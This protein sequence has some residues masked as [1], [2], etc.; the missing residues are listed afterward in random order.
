MR[1]IA[2]KAWGIWTVSTALLATG[3][4][5]VKN[6]TVV[7]QPSWPQRAMTAT[8][9]APPPLAATSPA[10]HPSPGLSAAAALEQQ[11]RN[12]EARA[13][14]EAL[15]AQN[16]NDA[17]C[18]HRLAVLCTAAGDHAPAADFYN[19]ALVL[20]P[21]NVD[22]LTDAGYACHVRAE[23]EAAEA[24]LREALVHA[25]RH[26]R[27]FNNLGLVLGQ[28]GRSEEALAA[29]WQVNRPVDAW[30]NMAYVYQ[31]R[32][33]WE[34]ALACYAEAQK[35]DPTVTVPATLLAQRDS[36]ARETQLVAAQ[37]DSINATPVTPPKAVVTSAEAIELPA[38]LGASPRFISPL[39][40]DPSSAPAFDPVAETLESELFELP[41]IVQ[42]GSKSKAGSATRRVSEPAPELAMP[43]ISPGWPIAP[44]FEVQPAGCLPANLAD[45]PG[46]RGADGARFD[47]VYDPAEDV[48][49]EPITA[50]TIEL[51]GDDWNEP[52]AAGWSDPSAEATPSGH[53]LMHYCL[54]LLH[55]KHELADAKPEFATV[56][57]DQRFGFS[58]QAAAQ[59][60]AADPERYLP[61]A[62]GLDV[63]AVRKGWVVV[64]GKLDHAAWLH[65][66]LF[67]FAS[68][69]NLA[70]FQVHPER[71]IDVAE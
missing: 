65:G 4:A 11:G 71:Y 10:S 38:A 16:P 37:T 20:D 47:V 18:L 52:V 44:Q 17:R 6:Q 49:P 66:K 35:L 57:R 28:T 51:V 8:P 39:A 46:K 68:A 5:A 41:L 25:P 22:L 33:K 3:C 7:D 59:R 9:P 53:E 42:S 62:G 43:I 54:V 15:L 21:K 56:Y 69:E 63:V 1:R 29:F 12:A 58:S 32:S 61:A 34:A 23:Y 50:E 13:A 27:A 64:A 36:A 31:Q 70:A 19:R 60:F 30:K 24:L 14:Y 67:L 40:A 2:L 48:A 45:R 26:E 55:E